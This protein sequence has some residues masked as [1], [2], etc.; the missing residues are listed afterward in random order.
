MKHSLLGT[1]KR[2]SVRWS[3]HSQ[4]VGLCSRLSCA[5]RPRLTPVGHKRR[6]PPSKT[7]GGDG[8]VTRLSGL[9]LLFL[10]DA[11]GEGF[12]EFAHFRLG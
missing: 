9:A 2:R 7:D 8:A 5:K 12:D 1:S 11:V 3:A 4:S 6:S 10:A